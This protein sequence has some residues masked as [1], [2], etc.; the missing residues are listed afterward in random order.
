MMGRAVRQPDVLEATSASGTSIHVAPLATIPLAQ[1][2]IAFRLS[3]LGFEQLAELEAFQAH[4]LESGVAAEFQRLGGTVHVSRD[5]HWVTF[6]ANGPK[7]VL[8]QTIDL[9]S[10]V[11]RE[12][13]TTAEQAAGAISRARRQAA[14]MLVRPA[15]ISQQLVLE[16]L[17]GATP[18]LL[19]TAFPASVWDEVTP[20][21]LTTCGIRR[22]AG[23]PTHVVICGDVDPE[24]AL[25]L[26]LKSLDGATAG[27]LDEPA[28]L[29]PGP[30]PTPAPG[31][32]PIEHTRNDWAVAHLRYAYPG[33]AK[34]DGL[35]PA[36]L[37]A[38]TALG[39]FSGR[40]N[41][42]VRERLGLAYRTDAPLGQ[43]LDLDMAFI[44]ADVAPG[45]VEQ[46]DREIGSVLGEFLDDGMPQ[47]E[48][49]AVI[50]YTTC[51]YA[52]SLASQSGLAMTVLSYATSG[53]GTAEISA[54]PGRI[55]EVTAAAVTTA[56]R[57]TYGAGATAQVVVR[58][59]FQPQERP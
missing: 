37:V 25:E 40:I 8:A 51:Q 46:A 57:A 30:L 15:S 45:A 24:R 7:E 52:L 9:V 49:E 2:Y 35:F 47:D 31:R 36:S 43:H 28:P 34:H 5:Q 58:P 16:S 55:R 54:L 56:A 59:P 17:Y 11:A 10:S 48:L 23:S 20:I 18:P 39:F 32:A 21:G 29:L 53:L 3:A 13:E 19:A 27:A 42:S 4:W 22:S 14:S 44:E 38:A 6:G 26:A 50:T 1:A 33:I 12:V 41:T